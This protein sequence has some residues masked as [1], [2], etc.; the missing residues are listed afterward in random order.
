MPILLKRLW[1]YIEPGKFSGVS[2]SLASA[3]NHEEPSTS[4]AG[5]KRT[6]KTSA[7]I[8][9]SSRKR[10]QSDELPARNLKLRRMSDK[11]H[12]VSRIIQPQIHRQET[13]SNSF[14]SSDDLQNTSFKDNL[15]KDDSSVPATDFIDISECSNSSW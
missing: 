5:K 14:L 10:K 1:N 11:Q 8:T 12:V 7:D 2:T 3:T 6:L 9:S 13:D 15:G 4:T